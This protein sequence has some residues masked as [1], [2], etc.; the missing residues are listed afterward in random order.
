MT[1]PGRDPNLPCIVSN[2]K[3]YPLSLKRRDK[4]GKKAK[5]SILF[6]TL[7]RR[8]L[9]NCVNQTA[10]LFQNKIKKIKGLLYYFF[11]SYFLESLLSWYTKYF[12]YFFFK[13]ELQSKN[14]LGLY[15]RCYLYLTAH[16]VS[17]PKY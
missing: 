15:K 7:K 4:F 9:T 5:F 2:R 8:N 16:K 11:I 17:R 6:K 12:F 14:N 13:E 3:W 1:P 10:T